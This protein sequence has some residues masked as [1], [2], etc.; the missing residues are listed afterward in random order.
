[1]QF[2]LLHN[3][4]S[5]SFSFSFPAK[6]SCIPS[7]H[8]SSLS[9]TCSQSAALMANLDK[10]EPVSSE[11]SQ[12]GLEAVTLP[13][14]G[15]P[16]HARAQ[17]P[18]LNPEQPYTNSTT[19]DHVPAA[20]AAPPPPASYSPFAIPHPK[21]FNAVNINKK[22]LQKNSTSVAASAAITPAAAAKAGSPARMSS[23]LL[24][25]GRLTSTCS[26][27]CPSARDFTFQVGHCQAHVDRSVIHS[28]WFRLV[29][30]FLCNTTR[31]YHPVEFVKC[32]TSTATCTIVRSASVSPC[33]QSHTAPTEERLGV[34]VGQKGYFHKTCLGKCK[35]SSHNL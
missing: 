29:A 23:S 21:R 9:L 16:L 8:P 2:H 24:Y 31:V 3:S 7:P 27:A 10:P 22:F 28:Y 19:P 1:M 14:S 35:V 33:W 13:A 20:P 12:D 5:A 34:S 32:T 4:S 30:S 11:S 26:T 17:S 18:V 15:E 25:F 6:V